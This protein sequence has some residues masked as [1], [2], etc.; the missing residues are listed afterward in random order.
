MYVFRPSRKK[1]AR[2]PES[3]VRYDGITGLKKKRSEVQR[4]PSDELEEEKGG[5]HCGFGGVK[6]LFFLTGYFQLSLF[7]GVST[8]FLYLKICRV[9]RKHQLFI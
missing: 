7:C 8:L 2:V 9:I 4:E 3:V 5:K 6:A 1:D